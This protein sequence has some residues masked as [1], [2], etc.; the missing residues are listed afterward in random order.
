MREIWVQIDVAKV[1]T[2]CAHALAMPDEPRPA[3][4]KRAQS[5][6][7]SQVLENGPGRQARH[8]ER[9]IAAWA[10]RSDKVR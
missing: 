2:D 3:I 7:V 6:K 1:L 5:Q 8:G 9:G 4:T 10:E